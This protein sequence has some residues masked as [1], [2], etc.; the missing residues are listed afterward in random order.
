MVTLVEEA[1]PDRLAA[2]YALSV[3]SPKFMH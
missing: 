1:L 3:L 2:L